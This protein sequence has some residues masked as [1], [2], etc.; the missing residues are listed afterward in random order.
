MA[1]ITDISVIICAYSLE[2]WDDLVEAVD[3]LHT[4]T[5]PPKQIIVVIDHNS[6]LYDRAKT[7]LKALV[8]ENRA[9]RGASGAR[10]V[11]AAFAAG[12]VISFID[13]DVVAN[14]DWVERTIR[15]YQDN[16]IIGVVGFVKPLWLTKEP[17]WF[18]PEFYW[19]VGSTYLGMPEHAQP[20]RNGWTGNLSLRRDIFQEIGGF[21]EGFGKVGFVSSPEDTDFCIRASAARPHLHWY[22]RPDVIVKHKIPAARTTRKYFAYRCYREGVGKAHLNTLVGD[23][24]ISEE[25]SY[26]KKVLPAGIWRNLSD[27]FQGDFNGFTRSLMIIAGLFLTVI[28]YIMGHLQLLLHQARKRSEPSK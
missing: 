27:A 16:R 4:Q 2:R 12:E 20:V 1:K 28:G 24:G 17:S 14:S 18:P 21:R 26:V 15:A 9:S 6:E 8:L 5:I 25:R 13:D 10:N 11:G 7:E 23:A 19:T 22:F 3:S